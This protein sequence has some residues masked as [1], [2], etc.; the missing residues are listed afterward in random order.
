MRTSV[1]VKTARRGG[2]AILADLGVA[3]SIADFEPSDADIRA[4][5]ARRGTGRVDPWVVCSATSRYDV[6]L[7]LLHQIRQV[8]IRGLRTRLRAIRP[9]VEDFAQPSLATRLEYPKD[10]LPTSAD[11]NTRRRV[12]CLDFVAASVVDRDDPW[13]WIESTL[14]VEEAGA[15]IGLIAG[16]PFPS[17]SAHE[18]VGIG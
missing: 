2:R 17:S 14:D 10:L 18:D 11:A 3:A 13:R 8:S 4:G 12:A 7:L 6:Y 5:Q 16:I 1:P 9:T 15:I